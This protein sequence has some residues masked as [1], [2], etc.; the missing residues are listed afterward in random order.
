MTTAI[1]PERKV[2]LKQELR[3]VRKIGKRIETKIECGAIDATVHI[4]NDGNGGGA[5][6][7]VSIDGMWMDAESLREAAYVFKKLADTLDKKPE[8]N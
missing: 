6:F 5:P 3:G 8:T 2:A 4:R 1:T 7:Q